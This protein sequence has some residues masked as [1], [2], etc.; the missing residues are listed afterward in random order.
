VH[1]C[2]SHRRRF[3]LSIG[4]DGWEYEIDRPARLANI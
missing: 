1:A 4:S 3:T 2:L